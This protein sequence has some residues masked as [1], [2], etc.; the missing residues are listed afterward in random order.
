[1]S[2]H[3]SRLLGLDN[4]PSVTLISVNLDSE[5]FRQVN[6]TQAGWKQDKVVAFIQW[7]DN[8]DYRFKK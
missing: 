5:Q 8:L 6:L 2:F 3:L 4:V 7:I 1:M